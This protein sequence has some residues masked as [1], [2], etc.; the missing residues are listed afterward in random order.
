M[1]GGWQWPMRRSLLRNNCDGTFTDVTREAG[2]MEPLAASQTAVW[3]DIDN[4]GFLDLFVG[5][6]KGPSQLFHNKGDGTFEEIGHA[7][8]VDRSAF[9]KG[10]VAED[11]DNDGWPDLYVSNLNGDN[12][13]YHNN[14]DRT[15]TE[16]AKQA[17]VQQPWTSFPGVVFRLRQ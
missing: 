11:Y 16:V 4:D 14:H 8:G 1:R 15:F 5:N 2:L 7:A 12:F 10:V 6:E 17:G 13:L 3:T 9:T